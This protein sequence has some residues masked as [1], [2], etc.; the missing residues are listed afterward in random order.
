MMHIQDMPGP[1]P[2][3]SFLVAM[4][5]PV[6]LVRVLVY[7]HTPEMVDRIIFIV[8]IGLLWYWVGL[9][10]EQ[11]QKNQTVFTFSRVRP[12]LALD[13]FLVAA[14]LLCG[15]VGAIQTK[16]SLYPAGEKGI[17]ISS[18]VWCLALV[19]PFGWDLFRS[20]RARKSERTSCT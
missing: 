2:Q 10:I 6:G 12:R 5:L 8:M 19:V 17:L 18:F 14:G 7:R 9:N 1:S 13:L 3:F 16:Q 11:W 20:V 4:N 15:L